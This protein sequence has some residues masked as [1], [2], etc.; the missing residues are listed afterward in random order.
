M[1]DFG[2]EVSEAKINDEL[3]WHTFIRMNYNRV[4]AKHRTYNLL[5]N[6]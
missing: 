6:I 5:I 4:V 2:R 1:N 3:L